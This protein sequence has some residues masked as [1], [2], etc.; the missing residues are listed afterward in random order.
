MYGGIE[1]GGTKTVCAVGENG[2]IVDRVQFPTGDNPAT[3]VSGIA[4]FF[5]SHPI[6]GLGLGTFGPCDPNPASP[7]YGWILATPKQGWINVDVTGMLREAIGLPVALTT[8]VAAA[9]LGEMRFGAGQGYTDFVYVTIGTGVGGAVVTGGQI[10]R[11]LQHPEPGHMLLPFDLPSVCRYHRQCWEGLASG[12]AM[13]ERLGFPAR[14]LAEDDPAWDL[15]AAIVAAGL[16]NLACTVSPQRIILGGG[17]G[18]RPA[19]HTRVQRLLVESL[20]GYVSGPDVVPPA[21][22]PDAG[23]IGAMTLAEEA[24]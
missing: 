12:P 10:V 24:F 3:L 17:V 8:D 2:T 18:T 1:T 22:G 19:L 5:A 14:D 16:H 9:A 11:G 21:L 15:E 6:A 20:G 13:Q 4:E 7:T 23:V